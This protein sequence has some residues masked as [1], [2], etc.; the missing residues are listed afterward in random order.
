[1]A[2]DKKLPGNHGQFGEG[3]ATEAYDRLRDYTPPP[4]AGPPNEPHTSPPEGAGG[5]SGGGNS[6]GEG[7]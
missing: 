4:P 3:D 5:D 2:G 1:M 6:G 7:A